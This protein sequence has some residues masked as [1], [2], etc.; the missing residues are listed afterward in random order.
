[1]TTFY[2]GVDGGATKTSAILIDKNKKKIGQCLGQG[3]NIEVLGL[4]KSLSNLRK[5]VSK[6]VSGKNLS[7]IEGYFAL[8]GVN[9]QPNKK[10]W[11]E[12]IK[13]DRMLSQISRLKITNDS[14][15]ALRSGTKMEDSVVII[16]GTGSNCYGINRQGMEASS[17]GMGQVLSDEGSGYS[18]GLKALHIINRELDQ[19]GE[20]S[21][22]TK[23]L[24]EKYNLNSQEDLVALVYGKNSWG[25]IE[26][27]Q[28]TKIMGPAAEK[29]DKMGLAILRNAAQELALMVKTVAVKLSLTDTEYTIVMSGSVFK[30]GQLFTDCLTEEIK[31]FSPFAKTVYPKMTTAEAAALIALEESTSPFN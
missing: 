31:K 25:K 16:S 14:R 5:A 30:L 7:E 2:L 20:K 6:A 13:K 27:A 9:I 22:M 15:A 12:A 11:E 1:M 8:A 26:I 24:F 4:R 18:I 3:S 28:I 21:L 23:L 19:R 10:D 17:G 29:G